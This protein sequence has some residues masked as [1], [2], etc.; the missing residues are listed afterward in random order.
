[1]IAS[2]MVESTVPWL[3]P[4]LSTR[5]I[6]LEGC[7][8]AI[9]R[10]YGVGIINAQ[11]D[12]AG[13]WNYKFT[14]EVHRSGNINHTLIIRGVELVNTLHIARAAL[15]CSRGDNT[16]HSVNHGLVEVS[17]ILSTTEWLIL[18]TILVEDIRHSTA[19]YSV[20]Q[21]STAFLAAPGLAGERKE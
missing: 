20:L 6:S 12:Y 2:S 4:S 18:S 21:H 10:S 16:S 11:I 13:A 7:F 9:Y 8:N 14:N 1:M 15:P 19:F 3:I 5:A 17:N